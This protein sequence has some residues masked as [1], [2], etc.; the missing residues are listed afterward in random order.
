M[1]RDETD[2]DILEEVRERLK[3]IEPMARDLQERDILQHRLEGVR[4]LS[5]EAMKKYS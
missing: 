3:V 2:R 5:P 4:L 1:S